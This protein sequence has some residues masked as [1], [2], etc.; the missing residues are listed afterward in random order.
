MGMCVCGGAAI[1]CSFGAAPSA[2][3]T[4][5]GGHSRGHGGADPDALYAG[6]YR[7]LGARVPHGPDRE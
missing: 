6:D 3:T 5:G 7:A 2:L 4:G 1:A